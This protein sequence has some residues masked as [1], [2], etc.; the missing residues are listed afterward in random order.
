MAELQRQVRHQASA[1]LR[2]REELPLHLSLRKEGDPPSGPSRWLCRGSP[3]TFQAVV[4]SASSARG[5]GLAGRVLQ[6][7]MTRVAALMWLQLC[8]QPSNLPG[9]G[10]AS[11]RRWPGHNLT[12]ASCWWWTCGQASVAC[13]LL[14]CLWVCGASPWQLSRMKLC[15]ARCTRTSHMWFTPQPWRM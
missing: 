11:S 14:S 13:L 3:P 8:R 10:K 1:H 6:N 7:H 2:L 15:I 12:R 5:T 9:G 4:G